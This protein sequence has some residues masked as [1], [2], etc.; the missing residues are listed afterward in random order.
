[1]CRQTASSC[2]PFEGTGPAT[3]KWQMEGSAGAGVS[4][5]TIGIPQAGERQWRGTER[6]RER[7]SCKSRRGLHQEGSIFDIQGLHMARDSSFKELS[8]DGGSSKWMAAEVSPRHSHIFRS[9]SA[10]HSC[11]TH[12][13][14]VYPCHDHAIIKPHLLMLHSY[15]THPCLA[16]SPALRCERPQ[17]APPVPHPAA[18]QLPAS[19]A[20]PGQ[21]AGA[22]AS[23]A[24]CRMPT[25]PEGAG[26]QAGGTGGGRGREG[27]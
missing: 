19:E 15:L 8:V 21:A 26:Q 3:H 20:R 23:G 9:S 11:L 18:R 16:Q 13:C 2:V 1:M 25:A 17:P 7:E 5:V 4:A 12:S 10:T 24:D 27:V 6:E 14:L 22:G